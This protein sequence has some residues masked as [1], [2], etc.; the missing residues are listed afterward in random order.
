MKS[1]SLINGIRSNIF[2]RAHELYKDFRW[3]Y[4]TFSECLRT[5][6]HELKIRRDNGLKHK[7]KKVKASQE[8][9]EKVARNINA[10][11]TCYDYI[12][13]GSTA[14]YT[15]GFWND[16]RKKLFKILETL[17]KVSIKKIVALCE[18]SQAKYFG[19]ID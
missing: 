16:L 12:D 3:L 1:V 10:F 8:R 4:P 19:L 7:G 6:W 15:W 13:G 17:N 9:I 5:A 11:N 18:P 2:R 14:G